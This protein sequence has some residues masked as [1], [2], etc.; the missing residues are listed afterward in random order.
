MMDPYARTGQRKGEG[1]APAAEPLVTRCGKVD[2]DR[3][4]L[5]RAFGHNPFQIG[6]PALLRE[7]VF[8]MGT[9]KPP[10]AD[11]CMIGVR[12][13]IPDDFDTGNR[14]G[15]GRHPATGPFRREARSPQP[16]LKK[17]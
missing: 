3:R 7:A 11:N 15:I 16:S 9:H 8:G 14:A 2:A 10:L 12:C 5:R 13:L 17:S 6:H 4:I 1:P